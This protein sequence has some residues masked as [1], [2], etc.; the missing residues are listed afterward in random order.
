MLVET[1]ERTQVGLHHPVKSFCFRAVS[2]DHNLTATK[3]ITVD[4][5]DTSG[6]DGG[7]RRSLGCKDQ[8]PLVRL[9]E[10]I[11]AQMEASDHGMLRG[12]LRQVEECDLHDGTLPPSSDS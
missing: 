11:A 4:L 9:A 8:R 10:I 5:A 7:P 3:L 12:C 1:G 2:E 6:S